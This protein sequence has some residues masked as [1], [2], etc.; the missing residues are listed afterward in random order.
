MEH[1]SQKNERKCDLNQ[2]DPSIEQL[3]N[4]I[5]I[6]RGDNGCPWDRKQ[7]LSSLAI[8]L[9]EETYELLEAITTGK[10]DE[11]CEELGDVLFQILFIVQLF[12]E[13]N[14]FSFEDVLR[15]ITAKMIR[16][17]PH[18]F[19]D[20]EADSIDDV[21]QQW[22]R[23]KREEKQNKSD[24][25]RSI[26]DSVPAS[27]PSL[28]RAYRLSERASKTGF[29]W[30]SIDGIAEKVMEEWHELNDALDARMEDEATVE[31][32]DLLF[33]LVNFAR[34]ARIHPE[35][36]LTK[37]IAKFVKRFTYMEKRM[38]D[39]GKELYFESAAEMDRYWDAAKRN[40]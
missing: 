40:G 26:L 15:H 21:K 23:I 4:I 30:E 34:F 18:V 38:A 37:S 28:M 33:A 24:R 35:N 9:K 20:G 6:L 27:L 22:A 2:S 29:D 32:G 14:V 39:A 5:K 11:I 17:H 1:P 3:I 13:K 19:S 10:T 12:A 8:Y 16:R 36:A 25:K 31:F 7:T